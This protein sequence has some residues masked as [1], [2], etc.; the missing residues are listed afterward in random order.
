LSNGESGSQAIASLREI[1]GADMK[2]VLITDAIVS[3]A[4]NM[5]KLD[6]RVRVARKP[7][8]TEDLLHLFRQVLQ[9]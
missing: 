6:P 9:I 7:I 3:A 8:Q 1:L 5:L 2:A 4:T